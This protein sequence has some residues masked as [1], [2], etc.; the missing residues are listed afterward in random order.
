MHT[1]ASFQAGYQVGDI[2]RRIYDPEGKGT[3]VEINPGDFAAAIRQSEAL[4]QTSSHDTER[5]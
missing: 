5:P 1:Q 3:L 4:L 2:A